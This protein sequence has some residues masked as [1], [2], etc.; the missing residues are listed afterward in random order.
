MDTLADAP[1]ITVTGQFYKEG[2]KICFFIENYLLCLAQR[3]Y[4]LSNVGKY[5]AAKRGWCNNVFNKFY[6]FTRYKQSIS[7]IPRSL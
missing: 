6:S 5:L 1:P 2:A 4:K 7:D 3:H